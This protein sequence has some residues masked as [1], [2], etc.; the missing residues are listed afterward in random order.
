MDDEQKNR[1]S[2]PVW[3]MKL[4]LL[5]VEKGFTSSLQASWL[6]LL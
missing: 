3:M 6:E 4:Y 2:P 1:V 5:F